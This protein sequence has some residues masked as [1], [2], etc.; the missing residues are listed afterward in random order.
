MSIENIY[1][2]LKRLD[3]VALA[4]DILENDMAEFIANLNRK[5]MAEKGQRSD[6]SQLSPDYENITKDIKSRKSGTAGIYEHVTLFD[7]GDLHRSI[8]TSIIGDSLVMDSNDWKVSDLT[9]KYGE[10]L[11][12]TDESQNELRAMFMPIFIKRLEDAILQ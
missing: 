2:N 4:I 8:F 5:Q 9:D 11:G 3:V 7:T 10:F 6:G 1:N 12:L